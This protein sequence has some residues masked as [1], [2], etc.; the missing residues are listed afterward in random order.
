MC[1]GFAES[2]FVAGC[3]DR[4]G[5]ILAALFQQVAMRTT[6]TILRAWMRDHPE[7]ILP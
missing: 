2:P 3:E 4:L 1:R 7:A 6:A 5:L